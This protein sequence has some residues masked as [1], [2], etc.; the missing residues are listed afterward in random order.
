M[1]RFSSLV[2]LFSF[3]AISTLEA[4]N[5]IYFY[6]NND[7]DLYQLLKKD[8]YRLKNF[9]TPA[10]AIYN[11]PAGAPVIIVA[12]TYPDIDP[13]MKIDNKLSSVIKRKK[14]KI[15]AEYPS[16]ISG[17]NIPDTTYQTSVER[18]IITSDYFGGILKPMNIIAVHDAHILTIPLRDPLIVMARVVGVDKAEYG[19]KDTKVYPILFEKDNMIISA[20]G[21]SNFSKGRYAPDA[22]LRQIWTKI[23]SNLLNKN[24]QLKNWQS[25]VKPA[26]GRNAVLP[27]TAYFTAIKKGVEWFDNGRFYVHS[28]WKDKWLKYQ[29]DGTKV[30]GPKVSLS[31]SIGNGSLG[32]LEGHMSTILHNGNQLY[33]YWMRADVQGEVAM[34]LAAAGYLLKDKKS[35]QRSD[36]LLNFLFNTSNFRT[37]KRNDPTSPSYG[38][39]GW[40]QTHP[41]VFY[42][43]D[44]ARAILGA[45]AAAGYLKTDTYDQKIVEAIMANFRTTGV[46]GYRGSKIEEDEII[47]N[48]WK[49]YYNS[50]LIHLQAHYESWMWACYLWLYNKTGYQPLLERSTHALKMMMEAYPKKWLWGSSLQM[51][52]LRILLPLAWLIRVDDT[53]EH[54]AWLDKIMKD[55]LS[56]QDASGAIREEIGEGK[57]EFKALKTNSD[58]GTDESSLIYR[59]G[60]KISDQLYTCNFAVFGIHEA[61]LATH[62]KEY[63]NAAKKLGDYLVRIQARSKQHTDVDGAWFRAFDYGKWDYWASNSDAGWGAWSTLTGWIQSWIVTTLVQMEQKKGFWEVTKDSKMKVANDVIEKMMK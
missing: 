58:Y 37:E 9:P 16:V 2:L 39:I 18:G 28:S 1:N 50:D 20:T 13:L 33:R 48:G 31:D 63:Y 38:L 55:V 49:H 8:G 46:N 62:N 30:T 27:P 17:L 21:L 59:N 57:G 10:A 54:R 25:D 7:N 12:R 47:K 52:R 36:N 34:T 4:Q 26:Y 3:F 22:S 24:I 43:D 42:G 35:S 61:Y 44:N 5:T 15:Y 41:H 53:P 29:N 6:G 60:D 23:I 11:A 14:L 56:Y 19:L 51:Q 32:I 40:A 45:I